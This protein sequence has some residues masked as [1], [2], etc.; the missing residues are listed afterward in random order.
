MLLLRFASA[1]IRRDVD[2]G[3]VDDYGWKKRIAWGHRTGT[4]S[5]ADEEQRTVIVVVECEGSYL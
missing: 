2:G 5:G 1:G 4:I 3:D